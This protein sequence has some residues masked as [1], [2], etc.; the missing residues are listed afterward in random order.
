MT[1]DEEL[2]APKPRGTVSERS[3]IAKIAAHAKW[4]KSEDRSAATQAARDG[5][6][7]KFEDEVDPDRKL[8]P[9]E[10]AR[11]AESARRAFYQRIAL[12]SAQARRAKT[13]G[14]TS[15]EDRRSDGT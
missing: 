12:K 2:Y 5:M 6:L 9:E 3:Q 11:R 1:D 14:G 4:A 8:L 15:G 10:R 13:K 7:R